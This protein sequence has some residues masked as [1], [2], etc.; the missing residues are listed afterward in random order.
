MN[1]YEVYVTIKA[2]AKLHIRAESPE[3]MRE[4]ASRLQRKIEALL[5]DEGVCP[6]KLSEAHTDR[7]WRV[8][9]EGNLNS[10]EPANGHEL[11]S[12]VTED[13]ELDVTMQ[14]Q[15]FHCQHTEKV[16]QKQSVWEQV[17]EGRQ[18]DVGEWFHARSGSIWACPAC[19]KTR[20]A[21]SSPENPKLTSGK[22]AWLI[23]GRRTEAAEEWLWVL[24][25]VPVK[26][27]P[28][29]QSPFTVDDVEAL[30]SLFHFSE[31]AKAHLTY[32]AYLSRGWEEVIRVWHKIVDPAHNRYLPQT[33]AEAKRKSYRLPS[34]CYF[35]E[36]LEKAIEEAKKA[37]TPTSKEEPLEKMPVV[38]FHC[39]KEGDVPWSDSMWQAAYVA[40]AKASVLDSLDV[41]AWVPL[42]VPASGTRSNWSFHYHGTLWCCPDCDILRKQLEH[43][44]GCLKK[45]SREWLVSP[46]DPA[47]ESLLSGTTGVLMENVA[48]GRAPLDREEFETCVALQQE[49]YDVDQKLSFM[50]YRSPLWNELVRAWQPLCDALD[51]GDTEEWDKLWRKAYEY[52]RLKWEPGKG[53]GHRWALQKDGT[54]VYLTY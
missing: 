41:P 35:L 21:L 12:E 8:L 5:L 26:P 19:N 43:Y 20:Q 32:A 38:C 51:K 36:P 10:T 42:P 37:A 11:P 52:S 49:V 54:R 16:T 40:F 17:K 22:V 15:C 1:L 7:K 47:A 39:K 6:V 3:E 46:R 45:D 30:Q 18:R 27:L 9:A 33:L 31:R 53:R 24:S 44:Q 34:R 4:Q 50:A 14:L 2:G 13:V 48:A 29:T 23:K 25:G 28:T